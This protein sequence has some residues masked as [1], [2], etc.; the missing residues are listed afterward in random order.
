MSF[1]EELGYL[2]VPVTLEALEKSLE[3][4]DE[5]HKDLYCSLVSLLP[6]YKS[7]KQSLK[8]KGFV[9]NP[10]KTM[11]KLYQYTK[12]NNRPNF[13]FAPFFE[14]L[15][16]TNKK[17]EFLQSFFSHPFSLK[18]RLVF[19]KRISD[20]MFFLKEKDERVFLSDEELLKISSLTDLHNCFIN[21]IPGGTLSKNPAIKGLF[22][23]QGTDNTDLIIQNALDYTSI[24][25]EIWTRFPSQEKQI[26]EKMSSGYYSFNS[27]SMTKKIMSSALKNEEVIKQGLLSKFTNQ[28]FSKMIP[29][30]K[31][32]KKL[33][34]S[35][36]DKKHFIASV[37]FSFIDDCAYPV[38]VLKWIIENT[39]AS[40]EGKRALCRFL[41][42]RKN[43]W[44]YIPVS[45][46]YY[47]L[48]DEKSQMETDLSF[49]LYKLCYQQKKQQSEKDELLDML[50]K[51]EV[52]HPRWHRELLKRLYDLR[53]KIQ[54]KEKIYK[55][56]EEIEDSI[57]RIRKE[58]IGPKSPYDV[59]TK[60]KAIFNR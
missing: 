22:L 15:E 12:E 52:V 34:D 9:F 5:S 50:I 49:Y 21:K 10:D 57:L 13:F 3:K 60:L 37:D 26:I 35:Y 16:K 56:L 11:G 58:N 6:L 23:I 51:Q 25:E 43:L 28:D 44:R 30:L 7:T 27:P 14:I 33:N 29:L 19:I 1:V 17:R 4:V 46:F 39:D 42:K 20:F 24:F 18:D 2:N 54:N 8:E 55:S 38:K 45:S 48:R 36:G 41:L 53:F 31:N 40:Y 59:P 32:A 47:F